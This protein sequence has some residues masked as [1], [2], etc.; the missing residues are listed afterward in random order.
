LLFNVSL[1]IINIQRKNK[2]NKGI[3]YINLH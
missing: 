1:I 3:Y 2:V